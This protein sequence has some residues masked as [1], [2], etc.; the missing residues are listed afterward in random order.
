[1]F[2]PQYPYLNLT[3]LNLDWIIDHFKE[4]ID[5]IN[6]LDAWRAN[7]EKEY[8]ELKKLYDDIVA[9]RFPNEM[10]KSLY[11]WVV[12]NATSIIGEL[13]K[14]VYF[15]ITDDGYF[16]AYIPDSWSDIIFGTTG[17]DTFPSGVDYGHLTLNY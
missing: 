1:M 2:F 4:F 9:G 5:A 15:N 6:E 10:R 14:T 16:V 3:D 17:Y 13:I 8:E 11:E 7:H 12:A